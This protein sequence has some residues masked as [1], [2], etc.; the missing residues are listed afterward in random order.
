M[1]VSE[2]KK[3]KE[4]KKAKQK[5]KGGKKKDRIYSSVVFLECRTKKEQLVAC[6]FSLSLYSTHP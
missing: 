3:K 6:Y 2:A 1:P 4:R 5:T